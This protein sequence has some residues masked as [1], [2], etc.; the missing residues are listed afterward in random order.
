MSSSSRTIRRREQAFLRD[1]FDV[2]PRASVAG[3]ESERPG[4][5]D[6]QLPSN[7]MTSTR[8]INVLPGFDS[9]LFA[10]DDSASVDPDFMQID[11]EPLPTYSEIPF[12]KSTLLSRN[13]DKLSAESPP[14]PTFSAS[15]STDPG[16]VPIENVF[17][18]MFC[19]RLL[20]IEH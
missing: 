10:G 6:I 16:L 8:H 5:E 20:E 15:A 12:T 19:N 3:E 14:L 11:R 2:E 9:S 1:L 4:T 18:S 7:M 13:P 17:T